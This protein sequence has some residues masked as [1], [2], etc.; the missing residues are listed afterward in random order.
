MRLF[1]ALVAVLSLLVVLKISGLALDGRYSL[2]AVSTA[3]AQS[4]PETSPD[5]AAD[6]A[7]GAGSEA[8]GEGAAQAEANKK[9]P[10]EVNTNAGASEPQPQLDGTIEAG[11]RIRLN[12]PGREVS[13]AELALL[14]SLRKRRA[15]LDARAAA[16]EMRE[17]LLKAAEQRI[18]EKLS[19]LKVY[20]SKIEAR[21]KKQEDAENEQFAN[22]VSMYENMKPKDAARIFNRLETVVLL[23]VASRMKPRKLAPVLSRMESASAERLTMEI[24]RSATSTRPPAGELESLTAN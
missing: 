19:A 5:A 23:N 8:D 15:E 10:L 14:E 20:D 22:L 13:S 1:P 4:V 18:D 9:P 17:N 7:Q 11:R 16:L 21:F 2:N 3:I 24:A 6:A 12:R